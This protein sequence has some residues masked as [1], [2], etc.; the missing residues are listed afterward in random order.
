MVIDKP[1]DVTGASRGHRHDPRSPMSRPLLTERQV[2]RPNLPVEEFI[3]PLLKAK[4]ESILEHLPDGCSDYKVLDLGCGG[5]P[6]RNVFE[7]KGHAY[8]SGDAQDPTGVVD[9]IAEVDKDLPA[10]LIAR[11]PFDFILCTEVMEHVADWDKAFSN[12]SLL[13]RTDGVIL[14][15]CPHFYILHEQPYDFWRPTLHALRFFAQRYRLEEVHLEASGDSWD[16]LGT[17]LGANYGCLRSLDRRLRHRLLARALNVAFKILYTLLRTRWLQA[18]FRF[19]N[20][21]Y[22]VYLA[23]IA[24]LKKA[25]GTQ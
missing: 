1:F 18:R 15:T 24:L 20:D 7:R 6:F 4:I 3:V 16:V 13:L 23:N 14:I 8:V 17:V 21:L 12:I 19:G 5:Q 11:G 10:A 2:Y 25:H 9:Y 22:P